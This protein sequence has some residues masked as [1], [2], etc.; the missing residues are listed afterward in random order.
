MV[1]KTETDKVFEGAASE[2]LDPSDRAGGTTAGG[3]PYYAIAQDMGTNRTKRD[4]KGKFWTKDDEGE[5]CFFDKLRVVMLDSRRTRVRFEDDKPACR[6]RDGVKG[7]YGVTCNKCEYDPFNKTSTVADKLRCKSCMSVLCIFADQIEGEGPEPFFLQLSA[8]G[9]KDY[10]DYASMLQDQ[11]KRPL[12]SAI[13]EI[14]TAERE[15]HNNLHF[16]PVFTALKALTP[17]L[18]ARMR[19]LRIAE[20]VRFD[21]EGTSTTSEYGEPAD[22]P[23]SDLGDPPFQPDNAPPDFS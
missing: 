5:Y 11:Y 4:N 17:E 7:Q 3:T 18:T 14:V 22:D 19:A 20:S 6:S 10:L 15:S 12:F 1:D 8:G 23:D 13:T 21:P 2:P 16:V 9:I